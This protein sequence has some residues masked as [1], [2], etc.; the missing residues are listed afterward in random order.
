MTISDIVE[1][2]MMLGMGGEAGADEDDFH[3]IK[4]RKSGVEREERHEDKI[5]RLVDV[6]AGA[7]SGVIKSFGQLPTVLTKKVV[8]F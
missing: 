5:K 2:S 1:N 4:R 7:H 8:Y 6:K 3:T